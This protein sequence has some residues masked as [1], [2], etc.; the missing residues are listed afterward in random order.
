MTRTIGGAAPT[1]G[2]FRPASVPSARAIG[3][4]EHLR[5]FEGTALILPTAAAPAP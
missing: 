3:S 4:F 5:L 1:V 2:I